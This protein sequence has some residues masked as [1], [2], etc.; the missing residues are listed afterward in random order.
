MILIRI[1][2]I[3]TWLKY[4]F[5]LIT[6]HVL[7]VY[8]IKNIGGFGINSFAY[9][10]IKMWKEIVLLI[11][12]SL[13]AY[14]HRSSA[15]KLNALDAMI[16]LFVLIG[17]TYTIV[18]PNK[19]PAIWSFRSIYEI[20]AFYLLGRFYFLK[21][22]DLTDFLK[23]LV[24]MGCLTS[25]FAVVQ[26]QFL[27]ADFFSEVYGVD[28]VPI[29]YSSHGYENL[30]APSTFITPHE[31][32]LFL[33][34]CFMFASYLFKTDRYSKKSFV[35]INV[36]LLIG[37]AFSL[38]RSSILIL[39]I[40]YGL[41]WVRN[42]KTTFG[43]LILCV[44]GA[45]VLY[46]IGVAENISSVIEG[47][48]PSSMGR[49][50]V[51]REFLNHMQNHPLGSGLGTI[52]V[53]VRRFIPNAPQ[54]EGE[55][56]NIFGMMGIAGGL[57]YVLILA[58]VILKNWLISFRSN[59]I[60]RHYYQMVAIIVIALTLREL[61]LPRDFTNYSIGWFLIGSSISLISYKQMKS[62]VKFV[63]T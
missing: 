17:I 30:R 9:V 51:F 2:E 13:F 41:Y 55:L 5:V 15:I 32:G 38:S 63:K 43:F 62:S 12:L 23:A 19:V 39:I 1:D 49:F 42:K 45:L 60:N 37:L 8:F 56:F 20:F 46:L 28:E 34:L 58:Y 53:V 44:F 3:R 25:I 10:L 40:C 18:A 24:I 11:L 33:V 7:F 61:I 36:L 35:F 47:E 27:G 59:H 31:F 6:V 26:V 21:K 16:L 14:V 57:G 48:D 4:F 52:G 29:A 22:M 50:V 54:F